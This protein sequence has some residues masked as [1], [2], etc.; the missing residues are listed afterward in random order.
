MGWLS[1]A[2]QRGAGAAT[3]AGSISTSGSGFVSSTTC[4]DRYGVRKE[5]ASPRTHSSGSSSQVIVLPSR[6]FS[7]GWLRSTSLRLRA[8]DGDA[9]PVRARARG[10]PRLA[11][12]VTG[13]AEQ[14]EGDHCPPRYLAI[15]ITLGHAE[16]NIFQMSQIL[17]E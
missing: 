13:A 10:D 4:A 9:V 14:L 12:R 1:V 2:L 11:V 15:R 17:I 5:A 16:S 7:A 3:C 8:L 6:K